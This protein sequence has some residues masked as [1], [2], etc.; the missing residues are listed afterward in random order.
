MQGIVRLGRE[1]TSLFVHLFYMPTANRHHAHRACNLYYVKSST[2]FS[3][4]ANDAPNS[5]V[6]ASCGVRP[7]GGKFKNFVLGTVVSR[8]HKKANERRQIFA[9]NIHRAVWRDGR[10]VRSRC[11]A[12]GWDDRCSIAPTPPCMARLWSIRTLGYT[13]ISTFSYMWRCTLKLQRSPEMFSPISYGLN[14]RTPA[15]VSRFNCINA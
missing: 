15:F 3:A 6:L 12:R 7:C 10:V 1:N 5:P 2:S 9:S 8:P 4:R 14:L 13:N 11:G